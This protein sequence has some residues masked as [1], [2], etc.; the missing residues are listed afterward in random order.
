MSTLRLWVLG[1]VLAS[2]VIIALAW[3]I[4][5]SPRLA[6]VAAADDERQSV[7]TVNAGYE[8]TLLE[9]QQ[10]SEQL[11]ALTSELETLQ[12]SIPE[13]PELSSLLGE[14]NAL[15]EASGVFL[16]SVVASEPALFPQETLEGSGVDALVVLPVAIRATG[17]GTALDGFVRAVQFSERLILVTGLELSEDP[18]AGS[19]AIT[20][21]IFVLPPAGAAL[22]TEE[23]TGEAPTDG[24]PIEEAPAEEAPAEG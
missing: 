4:G 3:F 1:S 5:V 21:L 11:P 12:T 17:A 18:V 13:R 15:A 8:A 24:A 7:E 6:E 22:P 19:V 9:L 16:E 20:G 2:I 10:L 23:A 14:L